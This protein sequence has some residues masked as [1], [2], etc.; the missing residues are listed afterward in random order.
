MINKPPKTSKIISW[1]RKKSP[2]ILHFNT[3][4][5]NGCDIEILSL[6]TP[7]YD[8]ER[9][10]DTKGIHS[11]ACRHPDLHRTGDTTGGTTLAAHLQSNAG[12]KMGAG[13]RQLQLFR[14]S[15]LR[16]L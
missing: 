16:I 9:F 13:S 2:W 15:F 8:V 10:W 12:P 4:G 11:P 5:C 3:G 7:Y 14:R 6:L 1:A